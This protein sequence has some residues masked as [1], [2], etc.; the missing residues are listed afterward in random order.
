[1]SVDVEAYRDAAAAAL[2]LTLS[3]ESRDGVAANLAVLFRMAG[4]L[5]AVELSPHD[6]PLPVFRP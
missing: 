6:E 5:D 3:P 4:E 2:D 1:M